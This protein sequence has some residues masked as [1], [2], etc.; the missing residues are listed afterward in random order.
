MRLRFRKPDRVAL[1]VVPIVACVLGTATAVAIGA[2]ETTGTNTACATATV[3]GHIIGV[4]SKA[5]DTIT[6]STATLCHT[7][8]YTVPTVTVTT[9]P[10]T[11]STSSAS[12]SSTSSTS[13]STSTSTTT[14]ST[15]TPVTTPPPSGC[16]ASPQACGFPDPAAAIGA[17]GAVGPNAPCSQLT[18]S[19]SVT[20]ST[21]GATVQ[22]LNISGSLSVNA[23]NVTVNNVCVLANGHGSYESGIGAVSL[24]STGAVVE[25]SEL[26]GANA[27]TESLQQAVYGQ[28][29]LKN[30]YILNCGECV[31][32]SPFTISDSY[33]N[34]NGLDYSGGYNG[35]TPVGSLDHMEA[36][37]CS[38]GTASFTH[39]TLFNP[40]DQTAAVFCDTHY[41]QGGAC[42]N[43][44]SVTGSLLGG[45]GFV[46]YPCGNASSAGSSTMA[47]TG[48]R[49]ARCITPAITYNPSIGGT[50]C[51]GST[52]TDE[53]AS[54][55][56]NGYW[57]DGGYFGLDA[58]IY[59]TGSGHT[60]S[61]NV[62]DDSSAAADC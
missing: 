24:N 16:F 5:V 6:G 52:S 19:G 25:N 3:R 41:G 42:D 34:T 2:G 35:S 48:N 55:D 58:Y 1:V 54:K 47:I 50:A 59:C 11:S 56:Q 23:P 22:N 17:T 26:G 33:I 44:I 31:W 62:W 4:D 13:S 29:T 12:T 57:P 53:A 15:T 46:M 9:T 18:P 60:W 40:H 39:D 45:G 43:H 49:F 28:G 21:A 51:R 20:V 10:T 27:T 14:T 7:V 61:G 38:D 32:G 37:Y 36:L 8:T 30:D